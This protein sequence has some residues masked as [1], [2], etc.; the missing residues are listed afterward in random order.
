MTLA[1]GATCI[2]NSSWGEGF[3]LPHWLLEPL[4]FVMSRRRAQDTVFH[5]LFTP[6]GMDP[7]V[8]GFDPLPTNAAPADEAGA[9]NISGIAFDDQLL[10]TSDGASGSLHS[11]GDHA[12]DGSV[13][14]LRRDASGV[15]IRTA[16]VGGTSL[17]EA[18]ALRVKADGAL[19]GLLVDYRDAGVLLDLTARVSIETVVRIWGPDVSSVLAKGQ[20]TE[21]IREG[22]YVMLNLA[23][24]V[25]PDGGIEGVDGG[26]G[27][28]AGSNAASKSED[29]G[30]GC[31][32]VG[33]DRGSAWLLILAVGVA[34][35]RRS[36]DF[37]RLG[38]VANGSRS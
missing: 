16:L 18:A 7:I 5:A 12:C 30:C 37:A 4:P 23:A 24:T 26:T 9:Y 36:R 15:L 17:E 27:G 6:Y 33:H 31:K 14:L 29:G 1:K 34:C 8:T 25:G 35:L 21:F 38:S 11:F 10:F 2:T 28:H 20:E 19:D 3:W 22:E 32:A 13:C